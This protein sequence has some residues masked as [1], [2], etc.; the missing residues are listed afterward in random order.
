MY[1]LSYHILLVVYGFVLGMDVELMVRRN[2]IC[3][4][5]FDSVVSYLRVVSYVV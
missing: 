4:F 5:L 2:L 1:V 3:K